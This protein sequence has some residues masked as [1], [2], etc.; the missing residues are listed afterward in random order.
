M[1]LLYN[2]GIH[3]YSFYVISHSFKKFLK[4]DLAVE[5]FGNVRAISRKAKLREASHP[6][7]EKSPPWP[8]LHGHICCKLRC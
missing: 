5:K 8:A 1:Y 3:I 7:T 6:M 4:G 2:M